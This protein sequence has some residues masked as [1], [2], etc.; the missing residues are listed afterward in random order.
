MRLQLAAHDASSSD[1]EAISV[2]TCVRLLASITT[3][4]LFATPAN[5]LDTML[6]MQAAERLGFFR[7]AAA[8]EASLV[9]CVSDES[10]LGFLAWLDSCFPRQADTN[11]RALSSPHYA[12]RLR[13]SLRSHHAIGNMLY[14]ACIS[15]TLRNFERLQ[16]AEDWE[17][18]SSKIRDDVLAERAREGHAYRS[19]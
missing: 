3:G 12:D 15:H 8:A 17:S 2:T 13:S 6:L 18:L 4:H 16:G 5:P 7:V 11:D 19:P 14:A 9:S 10:A 1:A